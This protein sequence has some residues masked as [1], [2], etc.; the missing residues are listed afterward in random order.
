MRMCNPHAFIYPRAHTQT[1]THTHTH[2]HT[3]THTHLH[4][5]T[6]THTHRYTNKTHTHTH[7]NLSVLYQEFIK[8]QLISFPQC[9]PQ[10]ACLAVEASHRTAGLRGEKQPPVPDIPDSTGA[11]QP[12]PA[13]ARCWHLS[14]CCHLYRRPGR[15]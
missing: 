11:V 10:G 14:G 5:Y 4:T 12:L 3:H 6:H 9:T 2:I 1:H 8:V 13:S 7:T 15:L